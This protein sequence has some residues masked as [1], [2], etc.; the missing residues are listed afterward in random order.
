M[1]FLLQNALLRSKR[2]I[3]KVHSNYLKQNLDHQEL[4]RANYAASYWAKKNGKFIKVV[5]LK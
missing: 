5:K 2:E 4:A 3:E 1:M